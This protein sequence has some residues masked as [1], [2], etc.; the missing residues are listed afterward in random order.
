[1]SIKITTN[2][3]TTYKVSPNHLYS[4]VAD[5]A[6]ILDLDSG[7][8]Y[9][10]N[11]VG[12]DIWQ[13]LQQPQTADKLLDLVLEEYEVTQEQAEQ[14]IQSILKEMLDKGLIQATQQHQLIS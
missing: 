2:Q 4:E 13:W 1:M 3:S 5:E 12:V 10:L 11:S 14:D 8:Y 6:V 9:G 7:V